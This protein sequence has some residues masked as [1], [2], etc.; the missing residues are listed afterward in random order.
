MLNSFTFNGRT[1]TEFGIKVERMPTLNRSARKFRAASVPGHNGNIYELQDAFEE[2]VQPYQIFAGDRNSNAVTNFSTI[3][4]WLHSAD[5]YAVLTDTYD[6]THYREAIFVDS[7]DVESEWHT[8]GRTTI[9]FRCRPEHYIVTNPITVTSG[10]SVMNPTAHI[11]LPKITLTGSGKANLVDVTGRD[12]GGISDGSPLYMSR[13]APSFNTDLYRGIGVTP[14]GSRIPSVMSNANVTSTSAGEIV[15]AAGAD[16]GVGIPMK[17]LPNTKY[18]LSYTVTKT[19]ST[20]NVI[21]TLYFFDR[22]GKYMSR[23]LTKST[24]YSAGVA[25]SFTFDTPYECGCIMLTISGGTNATTYTVQNIML[26]YGETATYSAYN[27]TTATLQIN[28]TVMEIQGPFLD[29]VIDCETETLLLEGQ[30]ANISATLKDTD[31]NLS[32]NYLQMI[33]N[34]NT[35]TFSGINSVTVEPRFWNL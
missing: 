3:A 9:N 2:V 35:F 7:M 34:V 28:D 24:A 20:D 13:V 4:E 25:V 26:N 17:V 8:L 22:T 6:P 27:P 32:A 18:S 21:S 30:S 33:P 5:G 19:G 16:F 1:S 15:Y 11:A 29:A 12:I 31:G 14:E 10:G 23:Y